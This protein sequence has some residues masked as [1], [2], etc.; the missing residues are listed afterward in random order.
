MLGRLEAT[1]ALTGGSGAVLG[2]RR[3]RMGHIYPLPGSMA[4]QGA[5]CPKLT[6]LPEAR[7]APYS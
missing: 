3:T 7:S 4:S 1:L 2:D 6:R 5:L